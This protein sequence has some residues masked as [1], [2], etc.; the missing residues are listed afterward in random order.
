MNDSKKIRYQCL[1]LL[2]D[3]MKPEAVLI[4]YERMLRMLIAKEVTSK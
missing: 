2:E 4:A 1:D 3:G